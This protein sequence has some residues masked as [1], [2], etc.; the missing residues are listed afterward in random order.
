MQSRNLNLEAAN[1][2]QSIL[3][4]EVQGGVNITFPSQQ[5]QFEEI[6]FFQKEA[7]GEV[8]LTR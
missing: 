6:K 3:H 4:V 8:Y 5:E 2:S 1:E 7:T